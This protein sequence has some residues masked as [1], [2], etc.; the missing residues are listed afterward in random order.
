MIDDFVKDD[1]HGRIRWIRQA[2]IWQL[3]GDAVRYPD[4]VE[5]RP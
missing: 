4:L 5:V 2:L 3:G 1:L